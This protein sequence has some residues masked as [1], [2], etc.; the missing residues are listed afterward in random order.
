MDYSKFID[1][2]VE[3][4]STIREV[5]THDNLE[6]FGCMFAG[7]EAPP[8]ECPI[9]KADEAQE[10]VGGKPECVAVLT[11]KDGEK[12][13]YFQGTGCKKNIGPFISFTE[14]DWK[15]LVANFEKYK[16]GDPD[17]GPPED[18]PAAEKTAADAEAELTS[19]ADQLAQPI[20]DGL[21]ELG[22]ADKTANATRTFFRQVFGMGS[23][24]AA[25]NAAR[26]RAG[27]PDADPSEKMADA[28][29]MS[30]AMSRIEGV[31]HK[32][33]S[34]KVDLT[35]SD[36]DFMR[37]CLR[38]RGRGKN[39]GV[40]IM[41]GDECGSDFAAAGAAFTKGGERYGLRLGNQN[42]AIFAA[43][44]W[45]HQESLKPENP[46][47]NEDGKPAI[48]WGG[49]DAA[50]MNS[51][52]AMDGVMNEHGP[53]L[54]QS[55]IECGR[56]MPCSG[57]QERIKEMIGAEQFN[58]NLLI[59]GAEQRNAGQLPEDSQFADIDDDGNEQ[60]L[61]D[62]EEARGEVN[63]PTALAWYVGSLVNSWDAVVSDPM[64]EGC[65]FDVVGRGP[66]GQQDDGSAVNQD[67]QVSCPKLAG[68]L[69]VNKKN[70]VKSGSGPFG[71]DEH[72]NRDHYT[73]DPATGINVK[74]SQDGK[75]VQYGKR[76]CAV[77]DAVETDE[78]G[79]VIGFPPSNQ[80][81]RDRHANYIAGLAENH[82]TRVE[83]ESGCAGKSDE[84]CAHAWRKEVDDYKLREVAQVNTLMAGFESQSEGTIE[85]ALDGTMNKMGYEEG[86]K[87]GELQAQVKKYKNLPPGKERDRAYKKIRVT[88]TNAYRNKHQN[89]PGFRGNIAI[90]Y[91]QTGMAT[92]NQGFVCTKPAG[93]DT[94][95]GSESD[96][97]GTAVAKIMGYGEEGRGPVPIASITGTGVSF[98]E[99]IAL[100]RR[101]KEGVMVQECLESTDYILPRMRKLS[102]GKAAKTGDS[103]VG[104][105]A[106][107]AEDFVRQLQELIKRI[108]KVETV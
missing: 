81:A 32:L 97:A 71:D 24:G 52:R 60:I 10:T 75:Q 61:N 46:A 94:Y 48:F 54:A 43:A 91:A 98:E 39:Q 38:L 63:G 36:R 6:E 72:K 41:P 92:Q 28:L 57:M 40:Y 65:D 53:R 42:S 9:N 76:G 14:S 16:G 21:A 79:K 86:E 80:A 69:V 102:E 31:A 35:E 90:E 37:N 107:K 59:F 44:E 106:M 67:V 26:E 66:T 104:N 89:S 34:G 17:Q 78:K 56:Q 73:G 58:L 1:A 27:M 108:D 11:K 96:G 33:K 99:G 8:A 20:A 3:S 70:Q 47:A 103:E 88:L 82:G 50:K 68:K 85:T 101:T 12:S 7:M 29:I 84:E 105:S 95:V 51:Y 15:S 30:N 22:F 18:S 4:G 13:Y 45:I 25:R 23:A 83:P 74:T 5:K 55:W 62:I 77:I 2:Y 93:G 64:F 87:F 49:T 19:Q 100:R